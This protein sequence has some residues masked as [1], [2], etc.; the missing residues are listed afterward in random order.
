MKHA[1]LLVT[2]TCLLLLGCSESYYQD[3]DNFHEFNKVNQRNKGWFPN[4]ISNDAYDLKNTSYLD[5]LTAF[6]TFSYSN[7]SYYDSIFTDSNTKRIDYS[8]FEQKVKQYIS[9]KP[10]WF[11]NL[12]NVSKKDYQV[13]QI[14][15]F[16]I[17]REVTDKRVY[18]VLSN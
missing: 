7:S 5:S 14:E 9:R 8:I 11:L 17:V 1:G 10:E 4:I 15:R 16:F 3:Y 12:Q 2:L 6:G 18:F 13:V